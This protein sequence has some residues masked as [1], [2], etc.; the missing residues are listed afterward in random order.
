MYIMYVRMY[1]CMYVRALLPCHHLLFRFSRSFCNLLF[2]FMHG[3]IVTSALFVIIIQF[4]YNTNKHTGLQH[5]KS[6]D[7][8]RKIANES[9]SS[10]AWSHEYGNFD[11]SYMGW[12]YCGAKSG[13][14]VHA[15]S[16]HNGERFPRFAANLGLMA[17]CPDNTQHNHRSCHGW[18]SPPR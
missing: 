16:S 5:T 1:V 4:Y 14:Y 2:I 18:I 17:F 9:W 8:Q 3:V 13:I 7:T 11:G 12:N 10:T 15:T 6:I